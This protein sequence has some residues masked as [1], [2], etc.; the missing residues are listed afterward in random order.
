LTLVHLNP[1]YEFIAIV[2]DVMLED[3][4]APLLAWVA[5]PIWALVMLV[6]G[7]IFFWQAEERY[8]LSD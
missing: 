2:R 8:G 3:Y 5:A 4:S 1:I 6:G 7:V